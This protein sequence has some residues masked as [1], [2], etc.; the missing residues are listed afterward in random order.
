M[1]ILFFA[2]L[3]GLASLMLGAVFAGTETA[4]YRVSK[5]RLK[6]DA[7]DGDTTARRFLWLVNNPGFF[8]ATLLVG[9]NVATYFISAAMV[10]FVSCLFLDATG[11]YVELAATLILTPIVFV[12][13]EMFPKYICLNAPNRM[14]R[15]F[16]LV[17]TIACWLFAPLAVLLW[18]INKLVA[19]ILKTASETITMSLGRREL[20]GILV[21]GKNTGILSDTQRRLAEGIFNCS[22]RLIKDYVL[23]PSQLPTIIT[24]MKPERVLDIARQFHLLTLPVYEP[25]N[26]TLPIGYVR[27]IDLEMSVRHQLDE[28]SRQLSQLLQTELPIHS[29]VEI[30]A[31]HSLLTGLIILQTL[32]SSFGCV[33]S[34]D[35]RC[36]G[37]VNADKLRDELLG[38]KTADGRR[39][40]AAEN[41]A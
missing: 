12:Y 36:L 18:G 9:H 11:F 19:I 28:Q 23:P 13:G 7:L 20:S 25:E 29:L 40:T 21:E 5:L 6:L 34:E 24:T 16:S 38:L 39:Q 10:L 30:S 4:Y 26:H 31:N 17:I 27:V 37:F 15:L 3:L 32:R 8:I 1:E 41:A 35:R 33:M 2:L 14:L 22:D